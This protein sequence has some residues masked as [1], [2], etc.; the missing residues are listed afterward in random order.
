MESERFLLN[1]LRHREQQRS[2]ELEI[3]RREADNANKAKSDFLAIISH[4]IRTPMNG[5]MGVID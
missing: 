1:E 4:E 2:A 3:A 5:I